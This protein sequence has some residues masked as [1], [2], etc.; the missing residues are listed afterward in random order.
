MTSREMTISS[1]MRVAANT[2]QVC[3]EDSECIVDFNSIG[4]EPRQDRKYVVNLPGAVLVKVFDQGR[5]KRFGTQG[6]PPW[7]ASLHEIGKGH[8]GRGLELAL[9]TENEVAPANVISEMEE[10]FQEID[11]GIAST[12]Q[13][14][15]WVKECA[16][17]L[18]ELTNSKYAESLIELKDYTSRMR[19]R[20]S[21]TS[22]PFLQF[23]EEIAKLIDGKKGL[24]TDSDWG[25]VDFFDV[26]DVANRVR[27]LSEQLSDITSDHISE[28]EI[29]VTT[30]ALERVVDVLSRIKNWD[31][32]DKNAAEERVDNM[33]LL[34]EKEKELR[35]AIYE[36]FPLWTSAQ[37]ERRKAEAEQSEQR[38]RQA[39]AEAS[40]EAINVVAKAY[41]EQ[42]RRD[43]L[44]KTLWTMITFLLIVAIVVVNIWIMKNSD[45]GSGGS[46]GPERI[47]SLI[48]RLLC[49]SVLG[50][51]AYWAGRIATIK[52][53]HETDNRLKA[54][55]ARTVEGMKE[56][57]ESDSAKEKIGLMSVARLVGI[58]QQTQGDETG[59]MSGDLGPHVREGMEAAIKKEL[60]NG[61]HYERR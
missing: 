1:L 6:E 57:A 12:Q 5:D 17:K 53:R 40:G 50:G 23:H 39:Q 18:E 33:R 49:T 56:G 11:D 20:L 43:Y 9:Q 48:T 37:A 34:K 54:V 10:K 51:I 26:R 35:H 4:V 16:D 28:D 13:K 30:A 59:P 58:E 27:Q 41:E 22:R 15:D 38:A 44:S 14:I 21:V 46:W 2:A 31:L 60:V 61:M 55:I 32:S 24:D 19:A 29:Q 25:T 36:W 45:V 47:D 42:A 52:L 7:Q 3:M 8:L